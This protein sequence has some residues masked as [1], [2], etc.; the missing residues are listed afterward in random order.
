MNPQYADL[1]THT[2]HSDGALSPEALIQ[3]AARNGLR[4]LA[5]TDHDSVAGIAEAREIGPRYGVDIVPGIEFGTHFE[6]REYHILGYFLNIEH[7]PLLAY[8]ASLKTKRVNRAK[9]IIR[10]LRARGLEPGEIWAAAKE[11]GSGMKNCDSPKPS[12]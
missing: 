2:H 8:L 5:I 4:V 6:G 11:P 12:A 9:A 1:H 7:R 10:Q 3:L